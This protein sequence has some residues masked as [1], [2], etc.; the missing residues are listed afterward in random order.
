MNPQSSAC[1]IL[2]LSRDES[3]TMLQKK[4]ETLRTMEV[5]N[6]ELKAQVT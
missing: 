2:Q 3:T 5:Q 4:V 6:R 1:S